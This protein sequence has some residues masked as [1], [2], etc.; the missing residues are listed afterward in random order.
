MSNNP[1]EPSKAEVSARTAAK[2]LIDV[3]TN[4]LPT[5]LKQIPQAALVKVAASLEA[6]AIR[7]SLITAYVQAVALGH[8][9]EEAAGLSATVSRSVR[10]ALHAIAADPTP[11]PPP[12]PAAAVERNKEEGK[13]K[14]DR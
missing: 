7:T 8:S 5:I 9:R 10:K 4:E 1:F 11:A 13:K 6:Y 12:A 14:K 2:F 3:P